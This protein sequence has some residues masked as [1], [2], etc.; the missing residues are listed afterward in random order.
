[1]GDCDGGDQGT[2]LITEV[3]GVGRRFQHHG[4]GWAEMALAPV[5]QIV[6]IDPTRSKDTVLL[7][8]DRS[9]HHIVLMHVQSYKP[10]YEMRDVSM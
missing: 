5:G 1:M 9:S 6:Q 7:R 2:K 3:P 8:S 4:V 10:F